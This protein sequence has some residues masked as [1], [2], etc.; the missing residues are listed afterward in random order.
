MR[1]CVVVAS[2]AKDLKPREGT[3]ER[4]VENFV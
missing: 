3:Q 1:V 2:V 4:R